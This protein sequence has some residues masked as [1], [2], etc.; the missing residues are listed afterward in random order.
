MGRILVATVLIFASLLSPLLAAT[1]TREYSIL[2]GGKE[3]G[4]CTIVITDSDDG[5]TSMK[6]TI[7]VKVP[8]IFFPYSYTAETQEWWVKDRL[9]SVISLSAE[10]S[11]KTAVSAKAENDRII[12]NVNGQSRA[13]R[14]DVWTA[15]FWKLADRRFHNKDVPIFEPDTGKDMIGKLEF[16]RNEN[17]KIGTQVEEC[18]RFRVTG[19]PSPTDLWFD[20]HHRLVRQEFTD[21]GQKTI[22]QLMSRKS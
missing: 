13:I 10:N 20:K 2:V 16:V 8:G 21:S 17:L 4:T 3:S 5:K 1:E 9:T 6:A 22:V 11:K 18:F 14:W 19:I 15:G 7:N 12:V